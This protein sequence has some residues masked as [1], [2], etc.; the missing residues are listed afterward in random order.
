MSFNNTDSGTNN[1]ENLYN[2][3]PELI[4]NN[5]KLPDKN[6]LPYNTRMLAT[7]LVAY[8]YLEGG[9]QE[10]TQFVKVIP[11][12]VLETLGNYKD[13]KQADGSI[14][15]VFINANAQLQKYNPSKYNKSNLDPFGKVL[16]VNENRVTDFTRQY[17]QH[18]SAKVKR[19]T[20]KEMYGFEP[21]TGVFQ[22]DVA[23]TKE[24]PFLRYKYDN[25]NVLFENLGN[26]EYK[27]IETIGGRG[28]SEYKYGE[29]DAVNFDIKEKE[30][31]DTNGAVTNKIPES[32]ASNFEGIRNIN[33]ALAKVQELSLADNYEFL[34]VAT[35]FLSQFQDNTTKFEIDSNT[36]ASGTFDRVL[37][38]VTLH[39]NTL[40]DAN[41]TAMIL[42]HEYIHS[43]TSRE[44]MNYYQA[45]GVTLKEDVSIP[46]HVRSLHVV[47][48]KFR[49]QF[50]K[51]IADITSKK[52]GINKDNYTEDEKNIYYAGYNI[53]EFMALALTSVEFQ[54]E[55]SK[56]PYLQSGKSF[57]D[58]ILD[59]IM[60]IVDSVYPEL[61]KDTLAYEAINKSMRFIVEE[62]T[63]KSSSKMVKLLSGEDLSLLNVGDNQIGLQQIDASKE[64]M[65]QKGNLEVP[66][67]ERISQKLPT[68]LKLDEDISVDTKTLLGLSQLKEAGMYGE[69][70]DWSKYDSDEGDYIEATIEEVEEKFKEEYGPAALEYVEDKWGE[71]ISIKELEFLRDNPV[72]GLKIVEAWYR[73]SDSTE[74]LSD[75]LISHFADRIIKEVPVEYIDKNQMSLFEEDTRAEDLYKQMIIEDKFIFDFT[76]EESDLINGLSMERKQQIEKELE[77]KDSKAEGLVRQMVK[78]NGKMLTQFTVEEQNLINTVPV[79]RK[80]EIQQEEENNFENEVDEMISNI[81]TNFGTPIQDLGITQEEWN[82]L[83]QAEK[84]RIKRCN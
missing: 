21:E 79:S 14:K 30:V 18:N 77:G 3:I 52:Q 16:G 70:F 32:A 22:I 75:D 9:I 12:E 31:I 7:D 67:N 54:N 38:K 23:V 56:I 13:V 46:S 48:S 69:I 50:A 35:Q 10:A 76:E 4:K 45:D 64:V 33:D 80:I 74:H 28:I 65:N 62:H 20:K 53:K 73:L 72:E 83:S 1:Q 42:A 68:T 41:K 60:R 27:R 71:D 6:G 78:P 2:A 15:K 57:I 34:K 58:K 5:Y 49:E 40:S 66:L 25:V 8:A 24:L 81:L 63:N 59:T 44:I 37:N 19:V 55:M 82:D 36:T 47:F 61:K 39:E 26:G 17:F 51:E 84:D 43:I 11:V 29:K